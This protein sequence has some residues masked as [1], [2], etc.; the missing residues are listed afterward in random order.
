M[1]NGLAGFALQCSVQMTASSQL[2]VSPSE[3]SPLE[4]LDPP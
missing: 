3:S 4:H 1:A 2:P